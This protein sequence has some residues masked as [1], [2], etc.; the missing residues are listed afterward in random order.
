MGF[1]K[2]EFKRVLHSQES[3]DPVLKKARQK[4]EFDEEL[5]RIAGIDPA[6]A[7][8][9]TNVGLLP[10][11]GG[12]SD[13]GLFAASGQPIINTGDVTAGEIEQAR[14]D[15]AEQ[16]KRVKANRRLSRLSFPDIF[17]EVANITA[18]TL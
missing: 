13:F 17:P 14:R 3:V 10:T 16:L 4:E 6:F 7:D 2:K 8:L 9:A 12:L 18:K 1:L 11:A 15:M 5:N